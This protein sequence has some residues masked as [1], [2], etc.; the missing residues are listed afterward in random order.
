[1]NKK[2]KYMN[3]I[4]RDDGQNITVEELINLVN[5]SFYKLGIAISFYDKNNLVIPLPQDYSDLMIL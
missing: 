4:I 5:Y 2:L 3:V 1:M